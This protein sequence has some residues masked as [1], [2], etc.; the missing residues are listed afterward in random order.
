[1]A[2]RKQTPD[3]LGEIL[4]GEAGGATT[5]AAE[6]PEAKPKQASKRK[7]TAGTARRRAKSKPQQ[8]EYMEVVFRDYDGYR[9]RLVNGR[10]QAGWKRATVIHEYLNLLGEQGWEMVAAGSRDDMEMPAYF[11]RLK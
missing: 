6:K 5:T 10:E 3:I 9:P 8:W 1:M 4:G 11:K 2:D 7:S